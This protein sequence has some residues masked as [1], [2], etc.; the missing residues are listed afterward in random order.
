[1]ATPKLA[2]VI[3]A[4]RD[5][6]A[7]KGFYQAVLGWNLV[8]DVAVYVELQ[9]DDGMRVGLYADSHFASNVGSTPAATTGLTRT[10]IYLHCD[11]LSAA[12]ERVTAAGARELSPR[13][14]RAWG[15][16]AAYFSDPEG[17]VVVLARP[18][19]SDRDAR[20]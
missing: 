15:D 19:S 2:L 9:A 7:M 18:L 12:V 3:L 5:L 17:N 16:E 11:D 1:M 20:G 10:E 4:V 13:A 6:A 14:P 8:V